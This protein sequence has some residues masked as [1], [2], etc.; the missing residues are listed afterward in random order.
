M[1]LQ[2][3]TLLLVCCLAVPAIH[4]L[5]AQTASV[6]TRLA[7]QNALFDELY[8]ADMKNDAARATA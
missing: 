8:Q 4:S 1:R 6:D 7:T 2:L 3:S 5:T